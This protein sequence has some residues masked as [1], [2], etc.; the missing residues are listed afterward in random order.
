MVCLFAGGLMATEPSAFSRPLDATPPSFAFNPMSP[1]K[2]TLGRKLFFDP[3]LS[4]SNVTS[5]AS[6][7]DPAASWSDP[8][9]VS[10]NDAGALM[11]RRS[12]SLFGVG[13]SARFG[14]TA[15]ADA[16]EGFVLLPIA[17]TAEM[18]QD[19]DQ[20]V[21]ELSE[22]PSYAGLFAAAFSSPEVTVAGIS[23]SLASFLRTIV[24]PQTAFDDWIEGESAAISESAKQGFELFTGSAGCANCHTGWRFADDQ[25]HDIGLAL[26]NQSAGGSAN[27][28]KTPSLCQVRARAPF[29]HDGRHNSLEDVIEHYAT[30]IVDRPGIS[31]LLPRIILSDQDKLNLLEFLRTL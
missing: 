12:Q 5:C 26:D 17:K 14:W 3:R 2:I 7:H 18:N 13:W 21:I 31:P 28:F 24:P 11:P 10:I 15:S 23:Q 25:L 20:L 1:E 8:R 22:D 4:G 9:G 27:A 16:L 6:C 29:M 19:L 30:G